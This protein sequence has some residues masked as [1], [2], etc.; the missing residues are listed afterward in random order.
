MRAVAHRTLSQC[1]QM[2]AAVLP[3][4]AREVKGVLRNRQELHNAR[5]PSRRGAGSSRHHSSNLAASTENWN[6][7]S[8]GDCII[9]PAPTAPIPQPPQNSGLPDSN[10]RPLAPKCIGRAFQVLVTMHLRRRP[11]TLVPKKGKRPT[12]TAA[13][14]E[15]RESRSRAAALGA[16]GAEGMRAEGELGVVRCPANCYHLTAPGQ[17][18]RRA[19]SSVAGRCLSVQIG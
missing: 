8:A 13:A 7:R 16:R 11:P 3:G 17:H 18:R 1:T 5:D 4:A 6:R 9:S 19:G 14:F 2:R 15:G 10:R 12:R